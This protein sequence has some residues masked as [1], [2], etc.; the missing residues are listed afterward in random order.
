[1]RSRLMQFVRRKVEGAANITVIQQSSFLH[2]NYVRM[3]YQIE[4][5]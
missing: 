1:M 2:S 3:S 5:I 4:N